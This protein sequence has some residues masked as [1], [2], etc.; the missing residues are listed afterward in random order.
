MGWY[1]KLAYPDMCAVLSQ[2]TSNA[3]LKGWTNANVTGVPL[4]SEPLFFFVLV[5]LMFLWSC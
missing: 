4:P 1:E 2:E 3:K 5:R